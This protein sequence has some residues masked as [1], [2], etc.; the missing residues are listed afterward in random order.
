HLPNNK[1]VKPYA[2]PV[3]SSP[4]YRSWLDETFRVANEKSKKFLAITL[5]AIWLARN[6]LVH[7][8]VRKTVNELVGFIFSYLCENK[9]ISH[10]KV[11][12]VPTPQ[13]I[14]RP[15]DLDAFIAE[16]RACEQAI[17]FAIDMGFCKVQME[18]DSLTFIERLNSY[19]KDKSVLSTIVGD[20]KDYLKDA[21]DGGKDGRGGLDALGKE[22]MI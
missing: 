14:W 10:I 18:G 2:P 9:E 22:C 12:T 17:W 5:W 1:R 20:I 8:G 21:G 13:Q 16:A 4:E 19:I 6:R 15:P 3:S 11:T 7:D